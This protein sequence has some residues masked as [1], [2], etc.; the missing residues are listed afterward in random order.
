M[1]VYPSCAIRNVG[2]VGHQGSGKTSLTESMIYRTGASNRL[3]K[4]D[5]GNTVSDYL[6]EE[7]KRK[8]T[9]STSLVAC[10]WNDHKMNL[11]DTPGFSDFYG[12]VS[13]ALR[14]ADSLI[15]VLDAVA[16]VEV[17]TEIIWE[18][19]EAMQIPCIAVI[20][21][22]DRENADF[23]R[24]IDSM[25][26]KLSRQ[27][28][29]VQLPI[30]HE[31]SYHGMVDLLSLKAYEYDAAGTAKEIP[32]P[33][34]MQEEVE[35]Y[36]ETLIDA[37]AEG[38]DLI[39]MKYLDGEALTQEEIVK[40]LKGGIAN[41]KLMP[42]ICTAATKNIGSDRLLNIL[43]NFAPSPLERL[44]ESLAKK[45]PAALVFKTMADAFVG[46]ISLFKVY[47]GGMKGDSVLYNPNKEIE[48]KVSQL[49]TMQGKTQIPLPELKLGDIGCVAKLT[50]TTTGD[51]LTTK[52]SGVILAGVEFPV[53]NYTVAIAPKTKGDED[54]LGNGINR[55]L[56]EDPTLRYEKKSR[57]Q[58]NF[59]HRHRRSACR[60]RHRPFETQIRRG[61]GNGRS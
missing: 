12:E 36:R 15:M 5:E 59:D 54:K 19:A 16:G 28:V 7:M 18:Q 53:A 45:E 17:S 29:P 6:P 44:D 11:M 48:E 34:D 31:A 33:A 1:K 21:R 39:I 14:V 25:K 60:Y 57:N 23:F 58:A 24:T 32:I 30:G 2:I 13:S 38:D 43:I 4:V 61:S 51:T 26:Q 52:T 37:A 55:L 41:A 46:K 3:G 9:V 49:N 56:E 22:M 10:E 27:I 40:G 42:V 47:Q 35:K 20:N 8:I 50:K